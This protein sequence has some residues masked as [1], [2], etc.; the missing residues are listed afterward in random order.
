[1][2]SKGLPFCP[3]LF[4]EENNPPESTPD[5]DSGADGNPRDIEIKILIISCN[6]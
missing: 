2:A 3:C 5:P 1:M 6:L 4:A